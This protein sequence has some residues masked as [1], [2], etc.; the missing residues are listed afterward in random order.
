[1]SK[2]KI[3]CLTE[4]L[5]LNYKIELYIKYI[6]LMIDILKDLIKESIIKNNWHF[7]SIIVNIL[8]KEGL[9]LLGISSKLKSGY[10]C[11]GIYALWYCY[12]SIE[13][14]DINVNID[15][16]DISENINAFILVKPPIDCIIIN[17]DF[18]IMLSCYIKDKT[19]FWKQCKKNISLSKYAEICRLK[20][21]IKSFAER[22]LL[23]L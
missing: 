2:M 7:D 6:N 23:S 20:H 1:M 11:H 9:D 5:N 22:T 17:K 8:F 12:V 15:I 18:E 19:V 16:S 14:P 13:S 10:S 4:V 21:I 3:V